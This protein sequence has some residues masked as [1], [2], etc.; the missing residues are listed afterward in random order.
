MIDLHMHV[1]PCMDDGS[2]SI[3]ESA[4]MLEMSAQQGVKVIAA[5]PHFYADKETPESFLQRRNAAVQKMPQAEQYPQVLL[6]AEVAYFQ[7]ISHCDD[8]QQMCIG[9]S[10]LLLVEMPFY[11]WSSRMVDEVLALQRNFAITPVLAHV[12]R[13]YHKDVLLK[14]KDILL[15]EEILFQA[16]ASSFL[17]LLTGNRMLSMLK[18]GEIH[19]LGSD[20]HS[21]T[22]RPPN[23]GE[24][25]RRIEKRLSHAALDRLDDMA[26]SFL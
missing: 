2:S 6:G 16:N 18:R 22:W 7:G 8:L 17:P 21:S 19:F 20:S 9:D 4:K 25:G 11:P 26:R 13:Y 3:E 10:K 14:F 15:R 12:D 1:L 5:T 23:M 24:A